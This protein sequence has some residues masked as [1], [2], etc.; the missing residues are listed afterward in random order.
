MNEKMEDYSDYDTA[1]GWFGASPKYSVI[2]PS[3]TFVENPT[4][5]SEVRIFQESKILDLVS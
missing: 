3:T 5:S 4:P 2:N 1:E